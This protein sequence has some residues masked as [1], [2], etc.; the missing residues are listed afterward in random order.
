MCKT[1]SLSTYFGTLIFCREQFPQ[2]LIGFYWHKGSVFPW[3]VQV[4]LLGSVNVIRF[5]QAER[6]IWHWSGNAAVWREG[7]W[8]YS[9]CGSKILQVV[10]LNLP[11]LGTYNRPGNKPLTALEKRNF[12]LLCYFSKCEFYTGGKTSDW[13]PYTLHAAKEPWDRE[14]EGKGS[15]PRDSGE[16]VLEMLWG[17]RLPSGNVLQHLSAA[18]PSL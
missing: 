6:G 5:V 14:Q 13:L 3:A 2:Y 16:I 18:L 15:H 8:R 10:P 17:D 12:F 7:A 9:A 4:F 1:A 11:L